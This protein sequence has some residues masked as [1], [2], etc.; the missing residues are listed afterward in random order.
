M[1]NGNA[2]PIIVDVKV[3]VKEKISY[4]LG[5]MACNLV[6]N[7]TILYLLYYYTDVFGLAA[8]AVGTLF[9]VARIWDAVN[10]PIMGLIV[11][12]THTRWGQFRPYL[13]MGTIPMAIA[14][15]LTFTTPDLGYTGKLIYAYVTYIL[16]GMTYTTANLPYSSLTAV[17]TQ[18]FDER[19][20]ISTIRMSF[21][22][23]GGLIVAVCTHPIVKSFPSEQTGYQVAGII[24]A[25]IATILFVICFKNT[26]ERVVPVKGKKYSFKDGVDLIFKN[27]PL[28]IVFIASLIIQLQ[29]N[30]RSSV[31]VYLFKYNLGREELIPVY[32]GV[33]LLSCLVAM[34]LMPMLLK[35]IGKRNVYL[36]GLAISTVAL[37][38]FYY[39]PVTNIPM[40]FLFGIV[41]AVGG[42][43]PLVCIWAMV[44]DTVEYGEWKTGKRGEGIIYSFDSFIQKVGI[45]FGGAFAGYVLQ[46]VGYV[47]NVQQPQNV[48]DAIWDMY[49]IAP[50][51]GNVIVVVCMLFYTLDK[52]KFDSIL[53]ELRTRKSGTA[54]TA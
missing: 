33:T 46:F 48:L 11:D 53:E 10:D 14:M 51:I 54:K 27:G 15:V 24:Y 20:T 34:S 19:S 23:V 3:P 42:A 38:G 22:I 4:G 25:A 52:K 2:D 39:T 40:L 16:L 50:I 7:M 8:A 6:F 36:L 32:L 17:M 12:R 29:Y 1:E 47:P 41:W 31:T 13:I 30:I 49:S 18:D 21:A 45:A 43:G 5:A 9:L 37:I 26:R 35:K 28:I 44:P